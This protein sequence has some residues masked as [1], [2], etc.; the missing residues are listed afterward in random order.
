MPK[1]HTK[2]RNSA[3][4]NSPYTKAPA[5]KVGNNVFKM[6]TD[7]GQHVLK[8]P[9]VADAIVNKADLKQSDIVLEGKLMLVQSQSHRIQSLPFL[10]LA[11]VQET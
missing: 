3:S 10:K 6:N 1:A 8:N 2:K 4:G 7:L 9:G 11:L 5:A